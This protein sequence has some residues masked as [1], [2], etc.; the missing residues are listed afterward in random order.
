MDK[1]KSTEEIRTLLLSQHPHLKDY[2]A[3]ISDVELLQLMVCTYEC[4]LEIK[5]AELADLERR[6]DEAARA[7]FSPVPH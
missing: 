1:P 6:L 5:E 2:L 4:A 7:L 3:K